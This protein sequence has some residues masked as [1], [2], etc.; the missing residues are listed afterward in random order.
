MTK[1]HVGVRAGT[2]GTRGDNI[3]IQHKLTQLSTK[4][5]LEA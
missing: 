1:V 2:G 4:P 5:T 3:G